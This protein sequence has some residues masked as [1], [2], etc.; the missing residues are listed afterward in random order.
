MKN[1]KFFR[2]VRSTAAI[3][4]IAV[5]SLAM[6]IGL[7]LFSCGDGAGGGTGGGGSTLPA[8]SG[9]VTFSGLGSYEGKYIIAMTGETSVFLCA[10]DGGNIKEQIAYG[11][12]VSG[13]NVTLKVWQVVSEDNLKDYKGNDKTVKFYVMANS[14]SSFSPD[15]YRDPKSMIGLATVNFTSGAG[16]G[17]VA[18]DAHYDLI[19]YKL[20]G[21]TLTFDP[22]GR[23]YTPDDPEC[24]KY[25]LVPGTS[26]TFPIGKWENQHNN[27]TWYEAV[28]FKAD[29]YLVSYM[30]GTTSITQ[31]G[32]SS[33][34]TF[35]IYGENIPYKHSGNILTFN[36]MRRGNGFKE[37]TPD[38]PECDQWTLVSGSG[39]FP[40]GKWAGQDNDPFW[41][42]WVEFK[43]GNIMVHEWESTSTYLDNT[44][45]GYLRIFKW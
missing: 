24:D 39:A 13:G 4:G 37:Y 41:G 23:D 20:T 35:T 45:G 14:S 22:F 43:A 8:T 7:S 10:Y 29:G 28:E 26:G 9:S 25:D 15:N 33:S 21:S 2:A 5:I 27:S 3:P 32:N 11:A 30:S 1:N 12:K 18:I 38:D 6:M 40:I 44:T 16:S 42:E 34:G 19:P 17:A 31:T 36:P